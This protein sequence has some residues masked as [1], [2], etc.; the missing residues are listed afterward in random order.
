MIEPW[1]SNWGKENL[2]EG[3]GEREFAFNNIL[4][5]IS[6]TTRSTCIHVDTWIHSQCIQNCQALLN[7]LPADRLI[8]PC[9]A[10]RS[11][12]IM[13]MLEFSTCVVSLKFKFRHFWKTLTFYVQMWVCISSMNMCFCAVNMQSQKYVKRVICKDCCMVSLMNLKPE[14]EGFVQCLI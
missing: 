1:W 9:L 14:S 10:Q 5:V 4:S 6:G 12:Q 11:K 8:N 13:V 7:Q 2:K 3:S